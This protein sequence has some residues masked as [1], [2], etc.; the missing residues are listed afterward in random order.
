MLK[1]QNYSEQIE[2]LH[3]Q[4]FSALDIA[5]KLRLKYPQPVYNYFKKRGWER[6]HRDSYK[7]P[8]LYD[9]DK[10]FFQSIDTEEKAY[11]FGFIC[12]DGHIS[13][14]R[15]AIIIAVKQNDVDILHKIRSVMQSTHPIK[16]HIQ[17]RN[18]YTNANHLILEQ[19]CISINS[20]ELI[21]PLLEMGLNHR[22]T[23]TLN[24]S[25]MNSIP[26]NLVHHFLRGYFDGD[27]NV[28]WG[29]QYNTGKK[30]SI[31]VT[32]NKD[33][34]ENTFQ[35]CFPSTNALYKDKYSKQ[36]YTWKISER[37]KV[38]DFLS[39][40]YGD[41]TIYLDRKYKVYQYALWSFKTGLIAGNSYFISLIKG[42]SAANP[43]VKCW[44]QVQRLMDETIT[45]PYGE[46]YNSDTNAQQFDFIQIEDIV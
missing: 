27:G 29:R 44:R 40:I 4:G 43:L 38:L 24:G 15:N 10:K 32:G 5:K 14:T 6:L 1:I 35:K 20:K 45:N 26:E 19:A 12:A 39:Y 9:V 3:E 30:Y 31:N 16:E 34:L 17:R 42:Q 36:C 7:Q 18:P 37:K 28:M 22:K 21:Q 23:Y 2:A 8:T 25:E 46:E 33:F 13:E 41:A 11:V